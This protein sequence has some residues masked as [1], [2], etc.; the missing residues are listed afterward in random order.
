MNKILLSVSL[1]ILLSASLAMAQQDVTFY[2]NNGNEYMKNNQFDD[3][4]RNFDKVIEMEQTSGEIWY[5]PTVNSNLGYIY[6]QKNTYTKCVNYYTKAINAYEAKIK[7]GSYNEES[8]ETK[9]SIITALSGA[10]LTRAQAYQKNA[11]IAQAANDYKRARQLDPSNSILLINEANLLMTI[12][13]NVEAG[14]LLEK[15][16]QVTAAGDDNIPSAYRSLG[17]IHYN[18]KEYQKSVDAYKKYLEF[19]PNDG[20]IIFYVGYLEYAQ[21]GQIDIGLQHLQECLKHEHDFKPK[22]YDF[23]GD[24]Y[25]NKKKQYTDAITNWSK[26]SQLDP[27]MPSIDYK[28]GM[29]HN[30]LKEYT[31]SIEQFN[32]SIEKNYKAG[33]CHNEIAKAYLSLRQINNA[34]AS[35][36]KALAL[37]A[38]NGAFLCTKGEV[39]E[40]R[41]N[42]LANKNPNSP[43]PAIRQFKNAILEFEKVTGKMKGYATKHIEYCQQRIKD[44]RD[45]DFGG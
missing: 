16:I 20:A 22:A 41:G 23:I 43:D 21:L 15:F 44:L 11:Q 36:N 42:I 29:A 35:I 6:F 8:G 9:A 30:K 4:I 14:Q 7:N 33:I 39:L 27:T 19:T 25:F 2:F 3:A 40:Q 24:I 26:A 10:L 12:G 38:R 5:T 34:E 31:K 18:N 32:K 17:T 45:A 1:I 28:L 37:E 13:R